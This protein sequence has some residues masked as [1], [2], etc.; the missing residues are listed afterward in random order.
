MAILLNG[1]ILPIGG[2]SSGRVCACN[3]HSRLVSFILVKKM[4]WKIYSVDA[5]VEISVAERITQ[6]KAWI[7]AARRRATVVIQI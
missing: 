6:Q 7:I 3:L 5:T 2:A 4:R 1:L